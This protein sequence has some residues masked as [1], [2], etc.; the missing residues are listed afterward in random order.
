MPKKKADAPERAIGKSQLVALLKEGMATKSKTSEI[1]GKFGKRIKSAADDAN[2]DTK[3]F[4]FCLSVLRMEAMRQQAFLRNVEYYLD[5]LREEGLIRESQGELALDGEG[6]DDESHAT[7]DEAPL[8][9][10][11]SEQ[12]ETNVTRLKQNIRKTKPKDEPAAAPVADADPSNGSG[13]TL[14]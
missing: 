4:G 1:A 14:Q 12:V 3:A 2:L 11:E 13:V 9:A 5:L 6:D 7:E 10:A 8:D